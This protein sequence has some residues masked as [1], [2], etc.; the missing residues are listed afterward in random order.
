MSNS[1][2]LPPD[3][4]LLRGLAS[5]VGEQGGIPFE[6]DRYVRRLS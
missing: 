6:S 1:S 3:A 5:K 4:T 2:S